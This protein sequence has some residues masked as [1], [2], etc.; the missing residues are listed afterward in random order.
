M[1][2]VSIVV[3]PALSAGKIH[4]FLLEER[5]GEMKVEKDREGG[6]GKRTGPHFD[7]IVNIPRPGMEPWNNL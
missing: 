2:M 6:R 3:G 4:F 1:E 7:T 5:D